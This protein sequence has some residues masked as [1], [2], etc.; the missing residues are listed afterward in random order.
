MEVHR[1]T[2]PFYLQLKCKMNVNVNVKTP[3]QHSSATELLLLIA[4]FGVSKV[5]QD[6]TQKDRN[7]RMKYSWGEPI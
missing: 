2:M 3:D 1:P 5:K 4:S 6:I 7:E